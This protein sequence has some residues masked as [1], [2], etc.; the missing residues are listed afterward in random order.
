VNRGSDSRGNAERHPSIA[1]LLMP[2][3]VAVFCSPALLEHAPRLR[4]PADLV[5]HRLLQHTTRAS[6]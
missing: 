2:E 4:G 6:A 5:A 3:D 1:T